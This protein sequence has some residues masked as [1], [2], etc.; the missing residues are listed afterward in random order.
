M[1]RKK[2]YELID[3][4]REYQ[5]NLPHH[6]TEAD[7]EHSIADWV[8]YIEEHTFRAK[9]AIY[10]MQYKEAMDEVRKVAA[11]AVA[12]MEHHHTRPRKK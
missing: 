6:S 4:E 1:E 2:V 3:G 8:I 7:N 9:L 5:N 10:N 12:S 11:L